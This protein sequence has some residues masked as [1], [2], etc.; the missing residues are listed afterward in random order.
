MLRIVHLNPYELNANPVG[1]VLHKGNK[2][3]TLCSSS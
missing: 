1:I 2:G 3:A